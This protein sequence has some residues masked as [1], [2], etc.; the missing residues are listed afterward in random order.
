MQPHLRVGRIDATSPT[1]GE[2]KKMQPHWGGLGASSKPSRGAPVTL[3]PNINRLLQ[4]CTYDVDVC[5]L[6]KLVQLSAQ[7]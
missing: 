5:K 4:H 6:C 3:F 2:D 7:L 1:G